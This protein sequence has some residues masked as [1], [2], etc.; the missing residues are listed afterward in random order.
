M[1]WDTIDKTSRIDYHNSHIPCCPFCESVLYEVPDEAAWWRGVDKHELDHPGYRH[2]IEWS[3]G[4]C[5]RTIRLALAAYN[6]ETGK[7][8]K[9]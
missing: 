2:F 3:Q 6:K 7:E 8:F 5:F 9:L 4:K 1:W